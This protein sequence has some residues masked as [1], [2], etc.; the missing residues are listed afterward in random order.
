M[1]IQITCH[2]CRKRLNAPDTMAG[3]RVKCPSCRAVLQIPNKAEEPAS[4]VDLLEEVAAAPPAAAMPNPVSGPFAGGARPAA[5][6]TPAW[7]QGASA[8]FLKDNVWTIV[9]VLS[10]IPYLLFFHSPLVFIPWFIVGA[11]VFVSERGRQSHGPKSGLNPVDRVLFGIIVGLQLTIAALV[12]IIGVVKGAQ[13]LDPATAIGTAVGFAIGMVLGNIPGWLICYFLARAFGLGR[14]YGFFGLLGGLA[15]IVMLMAFPGGIDGQRWQMVMKAG[16]DA[17]AARKAVAGG[18][19]NP[20]QLP[21]GAINAGNPPFGVPGANPGIVQQNVPQQAPQAAPPRMRHHR[22]GEVAQGNP[23]GNPADEA[24]AE[25]SPPNR[26]KMGDGMLAQQGLN[27]INFRDRLKHAFAW[28]KA[29]TRDLLAAR[30]I[31]SGDNDR[32]AHALRRAPALERPTMNVYFMLGI[33][34]LDRPPRNSAKWMEQKGAEG[35]YR[36]AAGDAGMLL[37]DGLMTRVA[38]GS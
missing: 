33:T 36:H 6:Q 30:L 24:P 34:G 5:R 37:L 25:F 20:Q 12:G 16:Q 14:T 8:G 1:P 21:G 17:A 22:I 18:A 3:A 28:D 35:D 32:L 10:G 13:Q 23:P 7:K 29:T 11:I 15:G 26:P 2:H 38:R 31:V 19:G 27:E 9:T 4:L